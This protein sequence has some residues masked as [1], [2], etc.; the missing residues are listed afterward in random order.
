MP[1]KKYVGEALKRTEDPRLITGT[2]H[3]VDDLKLPEMHYVAILRSIYAHAKTNNIDIEQAK[4]APGVVAVITGEDIKGK[5]GPVPCASSLDGLKVPYHPV[6]AQGKV[7]HVGEPVVAV[8]ATDRYAA[9]DALDLINVDYEPL[10]VVVDPIKALDP[11]SPVVHPEFGDNVAC[12][13]K[14]DGGSD[15]NAAFEQ[16]DTVVKQRLV[17]QRLIPVA[18]E[19][20]GALAQYLPGE[21]QLTLWSSTQIPHL[22]RT[23]IALMIGLPENRLRVITPEVGGGFGS[24]LNV[25]GEEALVAY[26]S[27]QLKK[28]VKWIE[29]R[30][31]NMLNTIHGRAQVNDVEVAVKKDGTILGL[32]VRVI[33]DLGAYFQLLTPAIPTLTGLMLSGPYKIPS[34]SY[35]IV[36][37]FTN[38]MATDA[39]RGA[40]RPEATYLLERMMDLIAAELGLDPADVRLKNFPQ[41]EEFPF[42]TATGLTYDSG[43]YQLTLNKALEMA[44]YEE[45]R[46][47]QQK[48]REQGEYMGIGLSTYVEICALGPS[49]AMP[50]GGW[51]SATVRVEPTGKVTVLSGASPHGQGQETSFAQIVADELGVAI[52]DIIVIHGDTAIVQYGIG[53]FGSRATA[54]GGTAV[55]QA[56][57]MVKEKAA[58]FAGQLLQVDPSELV[59]EDGKFK[60]HSDPEKSV[61]IQQVALEAYVAK[62][63][64]PNTS[65]GLDATYFFEPSNFTFPFG[66]HLVVA[67]VDREIGQVKLTRY[68]AVDDCGKAINPLLVDGQVHGGIVQSIGQA[69]LEEAVY[70]DFGQLLSGDLSNY[71]IP[72]AEDVPWLETART[73]TPTPVNPLGAKGVGEAGTIGATPAIVNAVIDALSPLGVRHIDMPLKPERLWRILNQ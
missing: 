46:R 2:S 18:M 60:V 28:P 40:G 6:L 61:T 63:L 48:K 10:D 68:V 49:Q 30:R 59:F 44:G 36:G 43:N 23:Q 34:I 38:T 51:E 69:L 17:N 12:V 47:Q 62:N 29:T 45:L 19:P 58:K 25:Y 26:L 7:H 8:V 72:K 55:Y 57:Q 24:K 37:V 31:E 64:P 11:Q 56:V 39:Y 32:K 27:M 67:E 66:A 33:G 3:Y 5:L 16:A 14:V 1:A 35:E 52:E 53:T 20:R 15:I 13:L 4:N 22:L 50:A 41:P 65:P 73:E 42:P 21:N 54:V 9:R 71:A 70:D